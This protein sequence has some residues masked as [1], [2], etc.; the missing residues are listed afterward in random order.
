MREEPK[1]NWQFLFLMVGIEF[2]LILLVFVIERYMKSRKSSNQG[3]EEIKEEMI[4]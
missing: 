4:E 3:L 2:I 1:T